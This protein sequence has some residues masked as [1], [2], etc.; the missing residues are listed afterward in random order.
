VTTGPK[1][2]AHHWVSETCD[3][4]TC[5][6]EHCGR[7]AT[8][9][10]GEESYPDHPERQAYDAKIREA[11][12]A[13]ELG[14]SGP[15]AERDAQLD[16]ACRLEMEAMSHTPGHNLTAYVCCMHFRQIVGPAAPCTATR[17]HDM[18]EWY[19]TFGGM[20]RMLGER[21]D[22]SA[23]RNY[24]SVEVHGI[25]VGTHVERAVIELIRP[26][27]EAPLERAERY[28]RVAEAA[29]EL[30]AEVDGDD[31]PPAGALAPL[32]AALRARLS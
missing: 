25:L 19:E 26:G 17:W 31:A 22:V 6:V 30:L 20:I 27:G 16:R 29:L 18:L 28:R 1:D 11:N 21:A 14:T 32:I 5:R 23:A 24:V 12:A 8:H 15:V 7:P 3:G 9:K 10:L 4:V 2:G 13:L